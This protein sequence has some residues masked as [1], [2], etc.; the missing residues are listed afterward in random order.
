MYIRRPFFCNVNVLACALLSPPACSN[1]IYYI[2]N[3]LQWKR[4]WTSFRALLR[5]LSDSWHDIWKLY[6]KILFIVGELRNIFA[7]LV[8]DLRFQV[9]K[10]ISCSKIG[11]KMF[12]VRD[13][14]KNILC[15]MKCSTYIKSFG[16]K[17]SYAC[18]N[19]V[20]IGLEFSTNRIVYV[21]GCI[22]MF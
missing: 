1:V 18:L 7:W 16:W 11:L 19:W 15:R 21:L 2:N 8:S 9:F 13:F 10:D 22:Y 3:V 4:H 20:K 6:T 5:T 14:L 17:I 12:Y